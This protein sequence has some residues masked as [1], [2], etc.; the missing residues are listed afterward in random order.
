MRSVKKTSLLAAV[1]VAGI[2]QFSAGQEAP[3]AAEM[4]VASG[5]HATSIVPVLPAP[6]PNSEPTERRVSPATTTPSPG[7]FFLNARS[8]T[9]PFTVDAAGSQ[10]AEVQLFASRGPALPWKR[11]DG[12]AVTDTVREFQ[13]TGY[14]DGEFWFATRTIDAAGHAHPSGPITPQLK[15]FVD[16]DKP[17][18]VVD[19]DA[20]ASGRVDAVVAI[21]DST[22]MT[23]QIRYVTNNLGTWQNVDV[24]KLPADGKL[25]F[26]PKKLWE[27]LSLQVV[28]T[29]AAKN[30]SA[31]SKLINRPRIAESPASRFASSRTGEPVDAN[32]AQFRIDSRDTAAHTVSDPVIRLDRRLPTTANPLAPAGGYA[33]SQ[34]AG[35]ASALDGYRGAALPANQARSIGTGQ[36]TLTPLQPTPA[37]TAGTAV[38]PQATRPFGPPSVYRAPTLA[39]TPSTLPPPAG[40]DQISN[41][42]DLNGPQQSGL[43][44]E[45]QPVPAK[46]SPA[47]PSARTPA[48]AMRPLTPARPG[49]PNG[50]HSKA[51]IPNANRDSIESIPTPAAEIDSNPPRHGV[52]KSIDVE[53]AAGRAPIRYSDSLRFS[54]DFEVEA[55]GNAGVESIELYGSTDGGK[56]WK[57]WGE[58][59]DRISPFDIETKEQGVFGFRIV[60]VGRNGLTSPRPLPGESPDIVIV[61]D[62]LKPIVRISGAQ[63]G[64]GDRI[65]S[66]VI[67][68]EAEDANLMTR[69]ITLSFSDRVDGPWTTVAAGLR[70]DGSYIWPADPGLPRQLYLRIDATDRAGN[71]GSYILD[72][73]ID[74]QG[75]APRARIRGFQSLSGAL[76][77]EPGEQ[78]A[79]RPTA[80]FK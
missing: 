64:E 3:P 22:P 58:D 79:T 60:V 38:Y 78:T 71:V 48:E 13:F 51:N 21:D 6:L 53:A 32:W 69:P 4:T 66:L 19:A 29:D 10:P 28:V 17:R 43:T 41:G 1:L 34:P 52:R 33:P 30:Q 42:F 68:Y 27:Q 31:I 5:N 56:S 49:Q 2:P 36:P 80:V 18:V 72:R 25:S 70:N 37:G 59:P 7:C 12:K 74:V 62:R 26:T 61:V 75:L 57:F 46:E 14:E 67:Q 47:Q 40:A 9:I 45:T 15:V 76:P 20:D 39:R 63:Y 65:G 50:N 44:P 54:L 23:I 35:V 73:P 16:T 8:F 24:R 55:I 77:A 11:I